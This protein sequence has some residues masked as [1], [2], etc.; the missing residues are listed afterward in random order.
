MLMEFVVGGEIFTHL[1]RAKRFSV[2][3]TRFYISSLVLVLAHLHGHQI[4]Y[5][6]LKPENILLDQDG[7]VK[8]ADFGFA[9]HL[10]VEERAWTLCGEL[11]TA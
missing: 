2:D 7:Y 1:R 3:I 11:V 5:R 10:D 4:L 8:V 9:R 6:D